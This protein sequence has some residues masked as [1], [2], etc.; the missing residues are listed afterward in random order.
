MSSVAAI[1]GRSEAF[2]PFLKL[3]QP[4]ENA[5]YPQPRILVAGRTY[6]FS[7]TFVVPNQLLPSSCTHKCGSSKLK[8]EHLQLP[9]SMGDPELSGVGSTLLDDMAPD[10]ARISYAVRVRLLRNRERDGKELVLAEKTRKV[11]VIPAVEEQP[12]VRVDEKDDEYCLRKEKSIRK[13]MFK[14]KTG[15]L[16]MEAAQPQS[17]RCPPP[18]SSLTARR[19]SITTMATV[20]LRFDPASADSPAP[21]LSSLSGKLKVAT[22]YA[23]APR[24]TYPTKETMLYDATQ[25]VHVETL[26]LSSRCMRSAQWARHEPNS[27]LS[28]AIFS[29]DSGLSI[30]DVVTACPAPTTA[31]DRNGPF[32]TAKLPVPVSL[33]S[34]KVFVP[35]FHSC[36]VS[37]IYVLEL[38]LS[39]DT[40]SVGTT[41]TIK[42]PLQIS[43]ETAASPES[44]EVRG[45]RAE[46]VQADDVFTPRSIAPPLEQLLRRA[47]T[48]N[49][50]VQQQQELPP[51][52]SYLAP[53]RSSGFVTA[54]G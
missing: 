39:I 11:R 47:T 6:D 40:G 35:S 42:L 31:Y 8:D 44:P 26:T 45:D 34:N 16:V 23:S 54:R 48:G 17:L 9:P 41:I 21:R 36:L 4:I 22:F 13:S 10:M 20:I 2:H 38:C 43:A 7:F 29:G 37:R 30:T 18:L 33:P 25:G 28:D 1:N 24:R 46:D 50:E 5:A 3:T 15:R 14:G 27:S 49:I 19:A 52:Y 32:Y 53:R 51:E 12:P